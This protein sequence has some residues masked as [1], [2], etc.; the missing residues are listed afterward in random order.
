VNDVDGTMLVELDTGYMPQINLFHSGDRQ[1]HE[2][3]VDA[4]RVEYGIV[5]CEEKLSSWNVSRE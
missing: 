2:R 1:G 4:G 5:R 3:D